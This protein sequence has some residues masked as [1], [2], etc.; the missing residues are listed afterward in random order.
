MLHNGLTGGPDA[1]KPL[2]H[3]PTIRIGDLRLTIAGKVRD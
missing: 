1:M 3:Q 2:S